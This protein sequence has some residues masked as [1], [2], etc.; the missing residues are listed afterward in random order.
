MDNMSSKYKVIVV[1]PPWNQGKTGKRKTRPN[2]KTTLGYPTL[3]KSELLKLPI[4]EWA[5][6]K[7]SFLWL[8]ATNSKARKTGEPILKMAFELITCNKGCISKS[9]GSFKKLYNYSKMLS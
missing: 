6:D 7:Q 2:Q 9:F 5:A 1:D 3:S 4:D 8:W